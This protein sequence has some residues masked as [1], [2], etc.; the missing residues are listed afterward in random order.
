M[1]TIVVVLLSATLVLGVIQNCRAISKWVSLVNASTATRLAPLLLAATFV[2]GTIQI[3][4]GAVGLGILLLINL[5]LSQLVPSYMATEIGCIPL[6]PG[7]AVVFAYVFAFPE[8]T[9][10]LSYEPRRPVLRVAVK[11]M[12]VCF[13]V[14]CIWLE[15]L[16]L[17]SIQVPT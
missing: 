10:R 17:A 14:L 4:C 13:V 5:Y 2:V 16:T 8:V 1:L 12:C 3:C 15:Y 9:F 6:W 11:G 7:W